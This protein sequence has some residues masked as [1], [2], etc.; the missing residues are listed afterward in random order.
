MRANS[1]F[2]FFIFF[3]P[4]PTQ[5]V[6]NMLLY[7]FREEEFGYTLVGEGGEIALVAPDARE[8]LKI[9]EHIECEKYRLRKF[10]VSI[11]FRLQAPLITMVEVTKQCNLS[12]GHCYLR[13]G[14]QRENEFDT[15][16]VY[17]VL[18]DLK[19][20]KAFH[21]LITGGEPFLRSD[22]VDIINYAQK[23]GFFIE[24]VT[25]GTL[26]TKE[27]LSQIESRE[28]T[29]FALSF[30][31]GL[32]AGL[33]NEE[34]FNLMKEKIMLVKNEGFTPMCWYIVT[35]LNLDYKAE[36]AQWC[37]ENGIMNN[38]QDIMPIG[39]AIGNTDLLLDVGD[40]QKNLD[41]TD[42]DDEDRGREKTAFDVCYILEHS[43]KACKGGRTF[44][45]IC[46]NGDVYPC[47]NCAAD[48]LYVAGNLYEN[49]LPEIW[50][51][52]FKDI[53]AFTWNDFQGCKTCELDQSSVLGQF[54]KLRC[55]PLS[56]IL[57]GDPLYCGATEYAKEISK[58][59]FYPL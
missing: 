34:A 58:Y 7:S 4:N 36:V 47:S 30:L 41:E 40:V 11:P 8:H 10:R 43:A 55:P 44:A 3:G 48:E 9:G 22:I 32:Q 33:T 20:M 39:R 12:C 52:S 26:L 56:R 35:K 16:D 59:R 25:N 28:R 5:R 46:A 18:D 19:R 27:I 45:Y 13:A 49:S 54:C 29:S 57:Y 53:L 42:E 17:S 37:L 50:Q 6:I 2:L 31:G 23:C 38:H 1:I 51:T 24:V 14:E 15:K 21:I